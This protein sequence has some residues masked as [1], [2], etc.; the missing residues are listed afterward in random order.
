MCR[1]VMLAPQAAWVVLVAIAIILMP[2]I[3]AVAAAHSLRP[4]RPAEARH[5]PMARPLPARASPARRW[6][7]MA[8]MGGAAA[9]V[10]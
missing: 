5:A 3:L 2:T 4:A 1:A 10:N 6:A 7:A 9:A 8:A